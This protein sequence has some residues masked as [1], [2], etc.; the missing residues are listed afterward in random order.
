MN[1]EKCACGK[2]DGVPKPGNR[3]IKGH[4]SFLR[5]GKNNPFYGKKKSKEFKETA[6]NKNKQYWKEHPEEKKQRA[7]KLKQHWDSKSG[8]I[9]KKKQ[10]ERMS[11]E[12][13]PMFNKHHTKKAI[14]K[15]RR[16]VLKFYQDNPEKRSN[17]GSFQKEQ[18]PW[19]K[20]LKYKLKPCSEITKGKIRKKTIQYYKEHP[21]AKLRRNSGNFQK[22]IPPWNKGLKGDLRGKGNITP[23]S[24]K[25]KKL[26]RKISN[27]WFLTH[28]EFSVNHSKRM[29]GRFSGVKNPFYGKH[30]TQETKDAHSKC[31]K[32]MYASGELKLPH[33]KNPN[34]QYGKM[35]YREDLGHFTRSIFEA[36]YCRYLKFFKVDYVY[37]P[38]TVPLYIGKELV[39]NYTPDF[40]LPA[41]NDF[42]ELKGIFKEKDIL[43]ISLFREICDLKLLHY[44]KWIET[45]DVFNQIIPNW[46]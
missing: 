21:E 22:G 42:V 10:S 23:R 27:D 26:L 9:R 39:Y 5:T 24:K 36:N 38:I 31:L 17:K 12:N 14:E 33:P 6:R 16:A 8:E 34:N 45:N 30:H 29:K 7:K 18:L 25:T 11:G 46:E 15:D 28:P 41:T 35:G 40:Y 4:N 13:H 1:E 3:F 19:N 37:E 43:K 44:N 2:C 20:G 32:D